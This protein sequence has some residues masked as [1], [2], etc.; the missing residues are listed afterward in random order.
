MK[1][2]WVSGINENIG[3]AEDREELKLAL[4]WVG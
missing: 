3:S 1:D 4:F 2:F